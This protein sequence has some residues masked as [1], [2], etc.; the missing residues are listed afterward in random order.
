MKKDITSELS[1]NEYVDLATMEENLKAN[2]VFVS[3]SGVERLF[4]KMEIEKLREENNEKGHTISASDIDKIDVVD[5]WKL[6]IFYRKDIK[7]FYTLIKELNKN[8]LINKFMESDL[9]NNLNINDYNITKSKDEKDT[10]NL[11]KIFISEVLKLSSE[12]KTKNNI[13]IIYENIIDNMYMDSNCYYY[14][15]GK[16]NILHFEL[17]Q[18]SHLLARELKKIIDIIGEEIDVDKVKSDILKKSN[19][20]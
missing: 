3:K 12:E 6:L 1:A 5:K 4:N 14:S 19:L 17:F 2:K 20:Q 15:R 7:Y 18:E 8:E 11:L 9:L 16:L 10:K 13:N